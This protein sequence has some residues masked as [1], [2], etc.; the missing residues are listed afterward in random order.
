MEGTNTSHSANVIIIV[1]YIPLSLTY[2]KLLQPLYNHTQPTIALFT[3]RNVQ[4]ACMSA[5]VLSFIGEF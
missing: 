1:I 2:T 5:K 3:L 4:H